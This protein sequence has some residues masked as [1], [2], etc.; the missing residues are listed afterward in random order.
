MKLFIAYLADD[1]IDVEFNPA[2]HCNE[3]FDALAFRMVE[4]EGQITEIEIEREQTGWQILQGNASRVIFISATMT[5]DV[6][7]AR[8]IARGRVTEM[9][10]NLFSRRQTIRARCA[11]KDIDKRL[12]EY[13]KANLNSKPAV[14]FLFTDL[15]SE[16]ADSYLAGRT[17]N[18]RVDPATHEITLVD[19]IAGAR[20]LD[21]SD[22]AVF[23]GDRASTR[24]GMYA[25]PIGTLR[26]EVSVQWTQELSGDV[27]VAPLMPLFTS[28]SPE[29]TDMSSVLVIENSEG[30]SFD[31][32]N[33]VLTPFRRR[34]SLALLVSGTYA[35]IRD[36]L[37]TERIEVLTREKGEGEFESSE[38]DIAKP[39]LSWNS[40]HATEGKATLTPSFL[41]TTYKIKSLP[42][43]F[44]YAQDREENLYAAMSIEVPGQLIQSEEEE[45]I[46]L[47]IGA[48]TEPNGL[49]DWETGTAYVK[50]DQV[51]R[52]GLAYECEA[53]HISGNFGDRR[54]GRFTTSVDFGNFTQELQYYPTFWKLIEP[55]GVNAAS[56]TTFFG[57]PR[58]Q[59]A[60][61]HVALRLRKE[62]IRRLRAYH[63]VLT[64]RWEDAP[65][66]CTADSVSFSCD[67]GDGTA[68]TLTGKVFSVERSWTGTGGAQVRVEV[69]I[70]LGT[71]AYATNPVMA[72]PY[73]EGDTLE[74]G[75][76]AGDSPPYGD[77]FHDVSTVDPLVAPVN[78]RRLHD[79]A[80]ARASKSVVNE[81]FSQISKM[82]SIAAAGGDITDAP[83][84][85]PTTV[86]VRMRDIAPK[87]LLARDFDLVG[88]VLRS[89]RGIVL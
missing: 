34:E 75:I 76:D 80:Y 55:N 86:T 88:N 10:E 81:S 68:R 45:P 79:W 50:G 29:L 12:V 8:L 6:M 56:L 16:R 66:V 25:P 49:P 35:I 20:V 65:D 36:A 64:Y 40:S 1:Q 44:D 22:L 31:S 73:V 51:Q 85:Y 39:Q 18:Y 38:M 62:L 7:D 24:P 13:A 30:W 19:D 53:D 52:N 17:A 46:S 58:G 15:D 72:E 83:V 11:P 5:D 26:A 70:S 78:P 3:Y 33:A 23:S 42:M 89:P 47:S 9:P 54:P 59:L 87:D 14:D 60:A 2:F 67:F 82:A 41:E 27:D 61:E 77:Y 28:L 43:T 69:A 63:V 74:Y 71:G 57:S 21:L 84:E 32:A 4:T 48:L 37:Y